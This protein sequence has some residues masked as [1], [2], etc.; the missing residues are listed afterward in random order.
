V[1]LQT[2]SMTDQQAL[3]LMIKSTYQES[4][5][6]NAKLQRAKL[7][8]CQLPTYYAGYKGWL[9][10]REHYQAKH[11]AGFNLKEFHESAL[12]QG[13]VPLPVLDGLLQ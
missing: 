9:A 13:A 6:A 12:K 3:D 4:E 7:S 8:S 10:V 1:R 11:G 2:L 5:E